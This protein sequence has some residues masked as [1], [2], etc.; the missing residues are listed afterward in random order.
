MLCI[1][2]IDTKR[3][4]IITKVNVMTSISMNNMSLFSHEMLPHLLQLQ[5]RLKSDLQFSS[6][7]SPCL[8]PM[9]S[10]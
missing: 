9:T 5:K 6:S 2:Y 10:P 1:I 3:I 7:Y 8:P 4:S